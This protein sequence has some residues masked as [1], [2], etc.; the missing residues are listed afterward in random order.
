MSQIVPLVS[1][2]STISRLNDDD[3]VYVVGHDDKCVKGNRGKLKW[4][5]VPD[6][7]D[8]SDAFRA[9][10]QQLALVCDGCDEI[11]SRLGI[12]EPRYAERA[13]FMFHITFPVLHF[14]RVGQPHQQ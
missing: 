4:Q 14:G 12:V 5:F 13:S 11:R 3:P 1:G 7:F 8:R 6:P 9:L 10:E 2:K